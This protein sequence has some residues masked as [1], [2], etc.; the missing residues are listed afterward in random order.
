VDGEGEPASQYRTVVCQ[1][2]SDSDGM[3][4]ATMAISPSQTHP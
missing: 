3:E 1:G 4:R 2:S